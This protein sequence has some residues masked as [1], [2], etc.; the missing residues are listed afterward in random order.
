MAQQLEVHSALPED[1]SFIPNPLDQLLTPVTPV[2]EGLSHLPPKAP[3]SPVQT[4]TQ[5]H[6]CN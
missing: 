2:L 4:H 5:A 6:T 3:D 1:L